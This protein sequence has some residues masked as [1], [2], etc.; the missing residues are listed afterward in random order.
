MTAPVIGVRAAVTLL[1]VLPIRGPERLDR[2]TARRAMLA[3]PAVGFALGFVCAL[4]VLGLRVMTKPPGE[5]PQ[6]LLPAVVGLALIALLTRGLHLDGLADVADSFG[7]R[8]GRDRMLAVMRESTIGAFGA[9]TVLFVVLIQVSALSVAISA[10]RGTVSILVAAM[11]SRL[12]ATWSCV[13]RTPAAR[14]DGLG[15]LVAGTVRRRDAIAATAGVLL[16]AALAGRFDFHGGDDGRAVRA[17]VAVMVGLAAAL[18]VRHRL[19]RRF[20]GITGD[21]LGAT[22]EITLMVCL[23]TMAMTIPTPALRFLGLA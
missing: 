20:G 19:V 10:H 15:A 3:A 16:V 12:A 23:L 1:T 2:T 7:V 5:R 13:E 22:I 18:L 14:P 6:T 9:I 21:T 17:V 11:T 4:V 8:G